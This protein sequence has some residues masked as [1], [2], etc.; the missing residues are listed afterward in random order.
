MGVTLIRLALIGALFASAAA[1]SAEAST[2]LN[3]DTTRGRGGDTGYVYGDYQEKG[4]TV[5]ADE[6]TDN[7]TCFVTSGSFANSID[8]TGAALVTQINPATVTVLKDDGSAFRLD[9]INIA[10]FYGNYSGLGKATDTVRFTFTFADGSSN[11][12][13]YSIANTPFQSVTLNTLTFNLAPLASFSFLP[14]DGSQIQ[15]DNITLSDATSA[16]PEAATWAMMVAGFGLTGAS[17]RRRRS[18]AIA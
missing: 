9:S 10:D 2:V 7:N 13:N 14:L 15:F 16:V 18:V 17:L 11:L 5:L 3:F 12:V 4:F 8:K 6:C 1:V